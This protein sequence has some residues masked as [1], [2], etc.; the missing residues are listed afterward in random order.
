MRVRRWFWLSA[1]S[2][3]YRGASEHF[4]SKDL[5]TIDDYVVNGKDPDTSF[6]SPPAIHAL[7]RLT[8]R[9]NNSRSR[10]F[11]LLLARKSPRNLTNGI[12]I[13]TADALSSYNKKQ[14]HHIFPKAYLKRTGEVG[15]QNTPINICILAASENNAI[16]DKDPC[17]YLPELVANLGDQ[18]SAVFGSNL[19][20][21]P[22]GT[23]YGKLGYGE[24]LELRAA[25][26]FEEVER[27]CAGGAV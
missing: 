14:F 10:A 4:I 2:E 25:L 17:E 26:V 11:I 6:G 1:F 24:F 22:A 12:A 21:D 13:D 16:S 27:L 8:F 15:E 20:P 9:S 18:A 5:E 23:D 3:R 19:M 7:P